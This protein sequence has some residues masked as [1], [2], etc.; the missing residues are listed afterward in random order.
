MMTMS[1]LPSLVRPQNVQD[2]DNMKKWKKVLFLWFLPVTEE[3][4]KTK[5]KHLG[6]SIGVA[7]FQ[8]SNGWLQHFKVRY[9]IGN[10]VISGESPGIDMI[11][12]YGQR[13]VYNMDETGLYYRMLPDRSLTVSTAVKGVKKAQHGSL[14]RR[15]TLPPTKHHKP[16]S[17]H[18]CRD[19]KCI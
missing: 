18:G 8:Y 7:D 6:D 17:T 14:K 2:M 4:L 1:V 19:Y 11:A 9:G 3:I 10:G 15:G 5:A 13:D 12:K 16:H